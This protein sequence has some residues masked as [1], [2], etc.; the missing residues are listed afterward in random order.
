MN[1]GCG[2]GG[3]EI[4]AGHSEAGDLITWS[5][6]VGVT[7]PVTGTG[8]HRDFVGCGF[9]RIPSG[10]TNS[11]DEWIP[12]GVAKVANPPTIVAT[13]DHNHDPRP[14]SIF[15]GKGKWIG[16]VISCCVGAVREAY[17]SN[18][19]TIGTAVLHHPIKSS[20]HLRSV[21]RTITRT[22]FYVDDASLWGHTNCGG[23]TRT[24]TSDDA[25]HIRSVAMHVSVPNTG[26]NGIKR[27]V[28]CVNNFAS[29]GKTWHRVDAGVYDGNIN[30]EPVQTSGVRLQATN[31]R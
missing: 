11:D 25:G 9:K 24:I 14:P 10:C 16:S 19:A 29:G 31:H 3:V 18:F 6:H 13:R 1:S 17:N 12:S 28:D 27:Q 4:G 5:E 21:D 7:N 23:A 8:P 2:I 20:D 26:R 30:S 15:D 22:N